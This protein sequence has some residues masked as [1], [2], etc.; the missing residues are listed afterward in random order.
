[1]PRMCKANAGGVDLGAY[2]C[3]HTPR[4]KVL[5]CLSAMHAYA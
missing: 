5:E 2:E 3:V 1:M 4:P